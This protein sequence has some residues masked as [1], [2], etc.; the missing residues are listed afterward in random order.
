MGIA[1][2]EG[3]ASGEAAVPDAAPSPTPP[4][5]TLPGMPEPLWA[6]SPS[7][8]LAFLDCPRRYRMQYLDRPSPER[9]RREE[10][11][12]RVDHPHF[13]RKRPSAFS[14]NLDPHRR[15]S[16]NAVRHDRIDLIVPCIQHWRRCAVE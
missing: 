3:T 6:G 13:K 15:P 8:L 10:P 5:A 16:E 14:L 7:K 12:S 1:T 2:G 4:Q 9:R 11:R